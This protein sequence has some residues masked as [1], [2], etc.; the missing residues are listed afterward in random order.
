LKVTLSRDKFILA[1]RGQV[2]STIAERLNAQFTYNPEILEEIQVEDIPKEL[3][4]EH[5]F[6]ESIID[7]Y[8]N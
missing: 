5:Q 6:V 2:A 7:A 4:K 3:E 1:N 8:K